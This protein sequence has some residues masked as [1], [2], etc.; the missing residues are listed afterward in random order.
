[1]TEGKTIDF[2]EAQIKQFVESKR[3]P[4]EIRNKVDIGYTYNNNVLEIFEMRPR[5]NNPSEFIQSPIAKARYVKSKEL[6]KLY[7]KRASGKWEAYDTETDIKGADQMLK[8]IGE[9]KYG[10]FWG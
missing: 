9:D 2:T 8:V 6:W 10:C 3:P 7:W 1:M 5:W 4:V